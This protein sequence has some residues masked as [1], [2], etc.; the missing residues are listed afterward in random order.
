LS[1]LIRSNPLALEKVGLVV[2]DEA[3][4]LLDGSR[5]VTAEHLL[6]EL[7]STAPACR[8]VL[9]TGALDAGSLLPSFLTGGGLQP[10]LL[11]SKLRPTRRVYGVLTEESRGG[12]TSTV[13]ALYPPVSSPQSQ[14]TFELA[15]TP[16]HRGLTSGPTAIAQRFARSALHSGLRTVYFV[17]QKRSTEAQAFRLAHAAT[18]HPS[19]LPED[20]VARL[21]VELGRPSVLEATAARGIAPHH[22]G[23]TPLEQHLVER[24][25]ECAYRSKPIADSG[26]SR[27]PVPVE[28][29]H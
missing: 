21:R 14:Q 22:A 28:A 18:D 6:T 2:F 5:G 19:T 4:L 17:S 15:F 24:W 25:V 16:T 23:L 8:F 12:G 26:A 10:V 3:H 7:R 29:D 13:L 1:S 20:S 11:E 9:M 27:S